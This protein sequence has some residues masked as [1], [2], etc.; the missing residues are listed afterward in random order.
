MESEEWRVKSG[1][2][3]YSAFLPRFSGVRLLSGRPVPEAFRR[4]FPRMGVVMRCRRQAGGVSCDL[5]LR[6]RL[7]RLGKVSAARL[8]DEVLRAS[9]S[10]SQLSTLNSQLFTLHS[11]L[12]TL[13][14]SLP[15]LHSSL[16]TLHSS[17]FTLHSS[18]S[19]LHSPIFS[20]LRPAVFPRGGRRFRLPKR[21]RRSKIM[22][23]AG[24]AGEQVEKLARGADI[25]G[26]NI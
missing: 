7:P 14:S 11:S 12:F 4:L 10:S 2:L 15:T 23:D 13:H 8:T 24:P 3:D 16:S 9:S 5:R 17:L 25:S 20:L 19:T 1:V 21:L 26:E 18:L 22:P 6:R